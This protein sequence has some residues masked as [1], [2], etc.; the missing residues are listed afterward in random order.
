MKKYK[1][2]T[3]ILTILMVVMLALIQA[4]PMVFA[5][6]GGGDKTPTDTA[7]QV[8]FTKT[9]TPNAQGDGLYDVNLKVDGDA[10]TVN[11][12]ADIVLVLDVSTSMDDTIAGDSPGSRRWKDSDTRWK[13]LKA[14]ADSF[15]DL[16][17]TNSKNSRIAIVVYGGTNSDGKAWDD[18]RTLSGFSS[19]KDELKKSYDYT[20]VSASNDTYFSETKALRKDA[21]SDSDIDRGA[22]NGQAGFYGAR[23]VFDA[24]KDSLKYNKYVVFMSDGEFN[25][26]YRDNGYDSRNEEDAKSRAIKEALDMK[27]AYNDD[28]S[29]LDIYTVG[30]ANADP[31][32][33]N[34]KSEA[35]MYQT[36]YYA[37]KNAAQLLE[38]FKDIA[39]KVIQKIGSDGVVTDVLGEGFSVSG[40]LP[41][42]VS[43]ENGKV[44]WNVGDILAS[45]T[46]VDFQV[47]VKDTKQFGPAET[48]NSCEL[49]YK[50]LSSQSKKLTSDAG[51]TEWLPLRAAND[52]VTTEMETPVKIDV[53]ANDSKLVDLLK[54]ND[55]VT[56]TPIKTSA[57]TSQPSHGTA[58]INED[59]TVTYTPAD[60]FFGT[61]TFKYKIKTTV[62][63]DRMINGKKVGEYNKELT[64]TATVTITVAD[65]K[66]SVTGTKVWADGD[67]QDGVRPYSVKLQLKKKVGSA[68]PTN[69]GS[70]VILSSEDEVSGDANK[71]AHTW[72]NL[73]MHGEGGVRIIYSVVELKDQGQE[74][75]EGGALDDNYKVTYGTD[76][77]TVTNTHAPETISVNGTKTWR[78]NDDFFKIRPSSIEVALYVDGQSKTAKTVTAGDQWK[79]EFADLPKYKDGKEIAYEIKETK[80]GTEAV[81]T[82][83]GKSTA[84]G[85]VVTYDGDNVINTLENYD[86]YSWDGTINVTKKVVTGDQPQKVTD[87][88]YAALFT[89]Q[90]CTQRAKMPN[91]SG[92]GDILIPIQKIKLTG[93]AEGTAKFEKIP[94]GTIGQPVTYYLAEVDANGTPVDANY[95]YTPTIKVN[96]DAGNKIDLTVKAHKAAAEVTN[97]FSNEITKTGEKVWKNDAYVTEEFRPDSITVKLLQNGHPY[98]EKE[99]T[100]NKDGNWL[101]SFE[102]LPKFNGDGVIYDYGV[103]EIAVD[104]YDVIAEGMDLTNTLQAYLAGSV[105][106][107][108]KVTLNGEPYNVAGVFYAG[109]FTD[110][111]CT[112]ILK[113]DRDGKEVPALAALP[114]DGTKSEAV[115]IDGLPLGEGGAPIVYYIAETDSQGNAITKGNEFTID[116]DH[117]EVSVDTKGTKEITITNDY[118][119][120]AVLSGTKTWNDDDNVAGKRPESIKVTLLQNGSVY[121]DPITGNALVKTV[122]AKDRW[123]YSFV[124]L[125]KADDQGRDYTYSVMETGAEL[126][127]TTE[128]GGMNITNTINEEQYY[129]EGTIRITKKAM[130]REKAYKADDVYYAGI[131]TDSGHT[132]LLTD[133]NG[134][135]VIYAIAL[136]NQSKASIQVPVPAGADGEAVTYYVTEVDE[137]GVPVE[138]AGSQQFTCQVTGGV[139]T[140]KA[141]D[142]AKVTFTNTYQTKKVP[143]TGDSDPWVKWLLL[144]MTLA[145]ITMTYVVLRR[146]TGQNRG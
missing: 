140:V 73:D 96:G 16:I 83:A 40:N 19:K 72:E 62:T 88:F 144:I 58:A 78:D 21:F 45:G 97:T 142:A 112:Q 135:D 75:P 68:A 49:A 106:I 143:Q 42:N 125:P 93:S 64:A 120:R 60:D 35:N 91:P 116:I 69:V 110:P 3:R 48:N 117:P 56:A 18:H 85:Y 57:I 141:G 53:Q 66:I 29:K 34:P 39:E 5:N 108:K 65:K 102:N 121:H 70:P 9:V 44:T 94:V 26:S 113:V 46:A 90:N 52:T 81:K 115:T 82:E 139:C 13:H 146:K 77:V 71:W 59:G 89:D 118:P 12:T 109:V 11:N 30:F 130:L 124:N 63:G 28:K 101:Y 22:T 31:D 14:A 7:G 8:R 54:E 79:Y 67:N 123:S 1:R 133:E 4:T 138:K 80:I 37:A 50:D 84:A 136:D 104:G 51:Q 86:D 107:T 145:A 100:A 38:A 137:Y 129:Y 111:N 99:V 47:K 76:K 41:K 10:I 6:E 74:I 122:S 95:E 17:L 131:F 92:G 33:L 119:E 61:D 114:V 134:E 87:T 105:S 20:H 36:G 55:S 24:A 15:V 2:R 25:R 32:T 43:V 126:D 98:Q 103:D 132:K 127:Y 27:K 23:K 128:V